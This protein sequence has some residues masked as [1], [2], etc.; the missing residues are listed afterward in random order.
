MTTAS[1]VTAGPG[2]AAVEAYLA[3]L[4]AADHPAAVELALDLLDAGASVA[5]VLVDVVAVAQREIG[6]R[7]SAGRWSVA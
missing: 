7:W 1:P 4:D 6:L 3:C 2:A 5:D